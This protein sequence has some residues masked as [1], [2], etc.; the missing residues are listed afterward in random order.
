[1]MSQWEQKRDRAHQVRAQV[2]GQETALAQRLTH[3]THVPL[4]EVPQPTVN[5]LARAARRPRRV[6]ALLDQ[7]DGQSA[8]R[9][10]EGTAAACDPSTDYHDVEDFVGHTDERCPTLFGA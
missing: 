8:S 3:E 7:R 2:A 1:M 6:V 9:A 5:Q 4:L 10:I